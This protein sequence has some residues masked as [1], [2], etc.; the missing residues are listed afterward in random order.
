MFAGQNGAVYSPSRDFTASQAQAFGA[1]AGNT[2]PLNYGGIAMKAQYNGIR[3]M[4]NS[5]TSNLDSANQ[6][7]PNAT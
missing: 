6:P 4:S 7:L 2:S 3:N 1:Y 5:F